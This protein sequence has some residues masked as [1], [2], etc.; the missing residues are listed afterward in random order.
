MNSKSIDI[1][2]EKI[3]KS[4]VFYIFIVFVFTEFLSLFNL[5]NR[6]W[7]IVIHVCFL[8]FIFFK[9]KNNKKILKNFLIKFKNSYGCWVL[10]ILFFILFYIAIY[11][12]PNT[13]DSMTYHMS[14]VMHWIEN[15]NV[16][17]YNTPIDRQLYSNPLAEYV[18]MNWY[19]LSNSDKFVNLVQLISL[20]MCGILSYLLIGVLGS[21]NKNKLLAVFLVFTTPMAILESTGTQNDLVV[22]FLLMSM[23]FFGFKENKCFFG[24]SLALG[25]LVKSNFIIFALPFLIYFI[26]VWLKKYGIKKNFV[27]CIYFFVCVLSINLMHWYRNYVYFGSIFGSKDMIVYFKIINPNLVTI[28][29]NITKYTVMQFSLPFWS[30]QNFL[31]KLVISIHNIL[32]INLND[33]NLNFLDTKY[34]LSV[35]FI[36][37][38]YSGN[39][40]LTLLIIV[41]FSLFIFSKKNKIKEYILLTLSSGLIFLFLFK[42]QPWGNRL[43]LPFF[44]ISVP[45]VSTVLLNKFFVN[46]I[47]LNIFIVLSVIFTLPYYFGNCRFAFFNL[48]YCY[49]SNRQILPRSTFENGDFFKRYFFNR[50]QIYP[51]F[52]KVTH[53]IEDKKVDNLVLLITGDDYEYP[54]W[55]FIKNK[56][57][58]IKIITDNEFVIDNQPEGK[59][60]FVLENNLLENKYINY[61]DETNLLLNTGYYKAYYLNN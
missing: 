31:Y 60:L 8:I 54:W 6:F 58:K 3:V 27:W 32:N 59:T 15:R 41:T 40:L 28:I 39:L 1:F 26:F 33:P 35:F 23:V 37:E 2:L 47:Y 12:P 9:L 43:I 19:L 49:P 18:V 34:D 17:F 20:A 56:G 61:L 29:S 52:M 42:W 53:L 7:I 14:R 46:K 10:T 55:V 45:V 50:I 22:S 48:K 44:M 25:M 4:F 51:H 16:N 21:K 36:N 57:L 13:W 30:Y 38:S 11:Y 24:L 5:I